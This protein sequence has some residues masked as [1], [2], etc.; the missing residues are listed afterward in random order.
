LEATLDELLA[1]AARDPRRVIDFFD[2][3]WTVI[4]KRTP[5]L[6][7]SSRSDHIEHVLPSNERFLVH[8]TISP[9]VSTPSKQPPS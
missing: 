4:T 7:W 1:L 3:Q 9:F 6:V 5:D 8:P 2:R